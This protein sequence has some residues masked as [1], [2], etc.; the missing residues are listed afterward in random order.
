MP[1]FEVN[2][3]RLEIEIG[4]PLER[5]STLPDVAFILGGIKLNLHTLLYIQVSG[6][7]GRSCY[8]SH[9]PSVAKKRLQQVHAACGQHASGDLDLVV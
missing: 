2:T 3:C 1:L 8:H 9:L 5:K 7:Q 4:R 6:R